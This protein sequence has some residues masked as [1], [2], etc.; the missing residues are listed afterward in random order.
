MN[1][2]IKK[3]ATAG[4]TGAILGAGAVASFIVLTDKKKRE[5]AANKLKMAKDQGEK[6]VNHLMQKKAEVIRDIEKN[7]DMEKKFVDEQNNS[8][9][10]TPNP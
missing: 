10:E 4:L 9:T 6:V 8:H 7:L 3:E 1:T 2:T 5:N